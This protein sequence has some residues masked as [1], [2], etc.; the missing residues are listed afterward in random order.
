MLFISLLFILYYLSKYTSE[1][2]DLKISE[3]ESLPQGRGLLVIPG[4]GSADRL[5]T[6]VH[7]LRLL[8]NYLV[9]ETSK[10]PTLDC[11]VYVY[12]P[13]NDSSFWGD[14]AD[15]E[16]LSKMCDI[17]DHP[18]KRVTENL[19][20]VQ[21]LF[22]LRN[23]AFVFILLDD[24]KLL[25]VDNSFPLQQFLQVM[26]KNKLTV[27]SPRVIA[28]NVGGGQQFRTIMQREPQLGS[29]GFVSVFV[30]LFAWI[31]TPKA[32]QA[33]WE[34]LYP[35]INPYGWG[36]D[37]WYDNYARVRVPGHK[38]AIISSIKVQHDQDMLAHN[39]GRTESASMKEK[40]N[41][42]KLQEKFY[43]SY[44]DVSLK[45]CRE[46]IRLQNKTWNGAVIDL[47]Y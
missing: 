7:N 40:W 15:I 39:N 35:D 33:L 47:L 19:Y 3:F 8:S 37:F 13:R 43:E 14:S 11:I 20:M 9:E 22:I 10:S 18:N 2:K 36:Y 45:G 38:M 46:K 27:A 30:E 24:C 5:K 44:F 16:Y 21:P 41:A 28:A 17:I 34:L 4:L 31:T 29:I 42:L 26:H 6:V 32:Y 12:S 1:S 25:P 23:Y